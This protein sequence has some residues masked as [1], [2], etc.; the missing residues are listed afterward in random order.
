MT[1]IKVVINI[2]S[3]L[4]YVNE[5]TTYYFYATHYTWQSHYDLSCRTSLL[6][7]FLTEE[8]RLLLCMTLESDLLG[9]NSTHF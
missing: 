9:L 4:A 8:H 6:H 2:Y 3:G 5:Q 7:Y 1:I